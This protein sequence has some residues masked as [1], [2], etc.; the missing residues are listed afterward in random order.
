[1]R[2]ARLQK[3]QRLRREWPFYVFLFYDLGGSE[4]VIQIVIIGGAVNGRSMSTSKSLRMR[5][6][7]FKKIKTPPLARNGS[8]AK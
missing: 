1:M 4:R 3:L 7:L 6:V 8:R 2:H 5:R